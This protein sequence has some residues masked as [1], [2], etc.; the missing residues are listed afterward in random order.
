MTDTVPV[1]PPNTKPRKHQPGVYEDRVALALMGRLGLLYE[2]ARSVLTGELNTRCAKVIEAH[3]AAGKPERLS[4]W[5]AP[6][7][8]ALAE[9]PTLPFTT[10]LVLEAQTADADE[11]CAESAYLADTSDVN[12]LDWIRKL[13]LQAHR[14][15]ELRMALWQLGQTA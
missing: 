10:R 13:D 6:I 3:L 4:R 5:L 1:R 12:R 8:A 11:E 7:R 15:L 14:C 2:S 9:I